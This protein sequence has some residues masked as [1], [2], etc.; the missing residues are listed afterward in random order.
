M[1]KIFYVPGLISALLI[2]VLFWYYGNQKFE[3]VNLRVIDIG[4]PAKSHDGKELAFAS[5]EP[6]R[7]W[8]YKKIIV[9]PNS[10]KEN[11]KFHVSEIKKLQKE[12]REKSGIEFILSDENT[13]NDIVALLNDMKLTKQPTYHLDLDKTGHF[14]VV[15]QPLI[16]NSPMYNDDTIGR[17]GNEVIDFTNEQ[18]RIS[19]LK[20]FSKFEYQL[21]KLPE[22]SFYI[23][24]G[25]LLFL[26]ISML[27]IKERFQFQRF[28][29]I[30]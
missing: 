1:K 7:K 19:L 11:S 24:F 2:P 14:F 20:G 9:K 13:Y 10:A 28:E 6:Y 22:Q 3:E 27:S 4:L 23:I 18:F 16:S 26:N 21:T 15:N 8:N 30:K 17:C 12:N 29:I 5:F 25:F